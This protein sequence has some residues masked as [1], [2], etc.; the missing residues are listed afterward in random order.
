MKS[1]KTV[2]VV[3]LLASLVAFGGG[4]VSTMVDAQMAKHGYKKATREQMLAPATPSFPSPESRKILPAFP[5]EKLFGK[6]SGSYVIDTRN[7]LLSMG[8]DGPSSTMTAHQTYVFFEDGG[9]RTL[10]NMGGKETSWNGNWTYKDGVLTIAG[11]GG[12]GN[13]YAFDLKVLWYGENEFELR[14]ADVGKY[15]EMLMKPDN[16]KSVQCRYESNGV[17]HTEMIV[18]A[19]G[20]ESAVISVQSPQIYER[21]GAVEL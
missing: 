6:W 19:D 7:A 3:A 14:F 12:D 11:A 1:V 21:E 18:S 16:M 13:K 8:Y 5:K 4:C 9:C 15:R 2:A 17:F 10:M 20:N